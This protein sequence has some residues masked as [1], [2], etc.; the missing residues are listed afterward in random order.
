MGFVIPLKLWIR[1][2]LREAIVKMLNPTRLSKQGIFDPL[3]YTRYVVPHLNGH[4]DHTN[5]IW[6]A[7]MFQLWYFLYI[8]KL[9]CLNHQLNRLGSLEQE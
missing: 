3:F 6:A 5:K 9:K 8:E 1:N 7:F 2:N 4:A